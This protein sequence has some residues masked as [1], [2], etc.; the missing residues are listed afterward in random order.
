MSTEYNVYFINLNTFVL[1][2]KLHY[3][4]IQLNFFSFWLSFSETFGLD[5]QGPVFSHEPPH[6]VE[7]SNSTGGS[8]ECSG[9]HGSPQPEVSKQL[10]FLNSQLKETLQ[11]T[12]TRLI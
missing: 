11:Y 5:L 3:F 8:I 12:F 4:S 7:F 2:H 6:K 9:A 1:L 10:F